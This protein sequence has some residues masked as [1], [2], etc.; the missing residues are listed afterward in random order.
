MDKTHSFTFLWIP[1]DSK[2]W[3]INVIYLKESTVNYSDLKG[4]VNTPVIY[5]TSF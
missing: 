1:V 3:I 4:E 2:L 5:K